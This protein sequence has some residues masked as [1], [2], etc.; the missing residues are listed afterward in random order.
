MYDNNVLWRK[1][2]IILSRINILKAPAGTNWGQQKE[3]ILNTYKSLIQ[4]IFIYTASSGSPTP[5]HH[6]SR[7]LK[8][9][10]ISHLYSH[11]LR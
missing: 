2:F 5:R 3:I 7:D 1:K 4:S 10:K 9:T 11:Q 8:L 6:Y